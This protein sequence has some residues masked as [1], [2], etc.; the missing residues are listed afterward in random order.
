ML[1]GVEQ[2]SDICGIHILFYSLSYK[3]YAQNTNTIEDEMLSLKL[4]WINNV[5]IS[6]TYFEIV[7]LNHFVYEAPTLLDMF[8]IEN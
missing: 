8:T 4:C 1:L 3:I 5:K 7:K 6:Q 2:S